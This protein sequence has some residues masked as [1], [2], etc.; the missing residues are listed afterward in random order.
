[1][2]NLIGDLKSVARILT[3]NPLFASVSVIAL[4]L[5]IGANTAISTLVNPMLLRLLPA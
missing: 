3:W 2:R 1:M 5:A 4:A